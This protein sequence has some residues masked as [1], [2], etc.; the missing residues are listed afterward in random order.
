M[1]LLIQI[2]VA[3]G[4]GVEDRGVGHLTVRLHWRVGNFHLSQVKSPSCDVDPMEL[5]KKDMGN[6]DI[7][8]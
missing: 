8:N 3:Q 4:T 1:C 6:D 2:N 5:S 7:I